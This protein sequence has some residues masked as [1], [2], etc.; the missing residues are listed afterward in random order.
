M[1]PPEI[2]SQNINKQK[3]ERVYVLKGSFLR[4]RNFEVRLSD[5]SSISEASVSENVS[6]LIF[7]SAYP[8]PKDK[9]WLSFL[10][11]FN[12]TNIRKPNLTVTS[13]HVLGS[14]LGQEEAGQNH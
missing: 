4:H 13:S 5:F 10:I 6:W 2:F 11:N 8:L 12:L 1:T 9:S 14:K 7:H 3:N